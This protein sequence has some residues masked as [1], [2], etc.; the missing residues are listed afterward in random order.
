MVRRIWQ[1]TAPTLTALAA[2]AVTAAGIYCAI[3]ALSCFMD[4]DPSR[5]PVAFPVSILGGIL[6][7]CALIGLVCAYIRTGR[8]RSPLWTVAE[9]LLAVLLL[10]PFMQ[11][12]L[13]LG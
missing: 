13:S 11:L 5:Y 9:V 12:W 8:G 7:L 4:G 6:C 10:L 3:F 1:L 2:S